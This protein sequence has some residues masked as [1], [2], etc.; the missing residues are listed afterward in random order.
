M[1]TQI[2]DRT[3][4]ERVSR[5]EVAYEHLPTKADIAHMESRMVRWLVTAAVISAPAAATI[6]AVLNHLLTAS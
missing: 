6:V 4:A 3:T 2:A 1:A 5:L